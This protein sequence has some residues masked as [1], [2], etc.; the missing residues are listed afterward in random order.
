MDT[1]E[2]EWQYEILLPTFQK[3][4]FNFFKRESFPKLVSKDSLFLINANKR[5]CMKIKKYNY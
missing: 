3:V 5:I 1:K 2:K 4:Y